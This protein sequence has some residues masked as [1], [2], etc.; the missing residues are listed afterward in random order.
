MK[1]ATILFSFTLSLLICPSFAQENDWYFLQS[2]PH[3]YK[4]L[5]PHEPQ[6]SSQ[7]IPVG[8]AQLE[9]GTA[10][11]QATEENPDENLI[12]MVS[13]TMYPQEALASI[14]DDRT[15]FYNGVI[16]GAVKGVSGKLLTKE[17][18][19]SSGIEGWAFTIDYQNGAAIISMRVFLVDSKLY[20]IQVITLAANSPNDSVNRFLDSFEITD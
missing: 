7:K 4:I 1:I 9:M 18:I 3:K 6:L 2:N 12:Y 13:H 10:T 11:F 17:K 20:S 19:T 14:G 16:D 15:E 5:F 8:E